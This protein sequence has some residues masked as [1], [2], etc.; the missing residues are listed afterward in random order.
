M[1]DGLK[2]ELVD[3]RSL[4]N[5]PSHERRTEL[6]QH[7]VTLF[8]LTAATCDQEQLEIYDAVLGRLVDMI[9]KRA[10]AFVSSKLAG[11]DNAPHSICVKLAKDDILVASPIL[12]RSS[13]LT[14]EDL[15]DI[16]GSC[17]EG[18]VEA[19]C[20]RTKIS[21]QV[22]DKIV[23]LGNVRL[24][25]RLARNAGA[26]FTELGL[27]R[28]IDAACGDEELKAR[29]Q[30]RGDVPDDMISGIVE[31]AVL[32]AFDKP[33]KAS[34]IDNGQPVNEAI[35]ATKAILGDEYWLGRYDFDRAQERV[36]D[37]IRRQVVDFQLLAK[38]VKLQ[39]FPESVGIFKV[40]VGMDFNLAARVLSQPKLDLFITIVAGFSFPRKLVEEMLVLGPWKLRISRQ[41]R[42]QAL[43]F[44]DRMDPAKA[45]SKL[46]ALSEAGA[47]Q[48]GV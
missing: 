33:D 25:K 18:H 11:I 23:D 26:Q 43:H 36:G 30:M 22:T 19:V 31:D 16:I 4:E 12:R 34:S 28:L 24:H 37:I 17:G 10:R 2:T 9:E 35:D 41:Q 47:I 14:D 15:V 40:L 6:A 42:E 48:I 39:E 20:D 3:F 13:V 32:K 1:M 5:D 46:R 38:H 45:K 7:V 8:S 29:L 27:R 21:G 44:F